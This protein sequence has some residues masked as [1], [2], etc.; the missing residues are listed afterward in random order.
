[1]APAEAAPT[2]AA[3]APAEAAA[4]P[5]E[6]APVAAPAAVEAAPAPSAAESTTTGAGVSGIEGVSAERREGT[7]LISVTLDDVALPDVV[8]LFTRLSGAN[9]IVGTT[10]LTGSV[11]ANLQDIAWRPALESILDGQNLML[12]EKPPMSG[13]YVIMPRSATA[14]PW[15]TETFKLSYLKSGEAT[16]LLKSMLG[17]TIQ[18]SSKKKAAPAASRTARRGSSFGEEPIER[19]EMEVAIQQDGRVVSYPAGNAVIVSTTPLKMDEVRKVL[20]VVDRP[21]P[22]VYIE[23]KI[24]QLGDEA[25]EAIGLDWSV[26]DGYE[27]AVGNLARDYTKTIMRESG[28]A[29]FAATERAAVY[30]HRGRRQSTESVTGAG[31]ADGEGDGEGSGA[32]ASG[33]DMGS[34]NSLTPTLIAGTP[35]YAGVNSAIP[36]QA[37]YAGRNTMKTRFTGVNDIRTAVFAADAVSLVMSALKQ[38]DDAFL[39]SN[40]KI[41]VANEERAVIDISRKD[42]YVEVSRKTEGTGDN[43]TYTYS[44]ELAVIPGENEDLPY[45]EQAFF[46]YGIKLNVT[47]RINN[48]S[49]ITV[50]IEPTISTLYDYYE[51]AIGLTRYPVIDLKRVSTTF[52]VGDGKTAV[53]GGLTETTDQETVKKIPLLGDI[54]LI[55]KYLFTHTKKAKVQRETI[56]F[57]TVG[58]VGADE[59]DVRTRTPEASR[60]IHKHITPEGKLVDP[61]KTTTAESPAVTAASA[62]ESAL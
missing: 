40:P 12:I 21:R 15:I 59:T 49:N 10:N 62:E 22:Q 4:T 19:E 24:I 47:P 17:L 18:E 20:Q 41:V 16:T 60:L 45:V 58:V 8:R 2:E 29:D 7:E 30:D 34:A 42:P 56:I 27:V 54:P 25:K 53:I 55:G 14:E 31:A 48:A 9:I 1:A 43:T 26:L 39:V 46:T 37:D 33:A 11:T 5:A 57:V 51:P 61:A 50:V 52:S 3:A 13:V 28:A 6:A 38:S 36:G 23:A 44:T 35:A 32:T